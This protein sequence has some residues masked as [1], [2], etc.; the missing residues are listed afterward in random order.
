MFLWNTSSLPIL[1]LGSEF[2]DPVEAATFPQKKLRYWN[3]DIQLKVDPQLFAAFTPLPNNLPQPLALR[4][5]GHQF[6]HYNPHLGDGRGFLFAQ[7]QQNNQWYDLGT[8]GSGPTPYSR[9][10]DGRLTLKGAFRESLATELLQ[11]LGVKTSKTLCFFETG[12]NLVRNDEPSPTRSAVLT[13]F[14]L[15]H[16]R[17]GTFQR[18]AFLQQKE[19][20]K[21]LISYCMHFYYP[22]EL[23]KIDA[24][25]DNL[26]AARFLYNVIES[27]A[28][29]AAQVMMSGFV[30]GVLNTDNISIAGELFDYGPY[31]FM[32]EYDPNFT[33]AYFDEQGLYCFGR[34]PASFLWALHQLAASLKQAYPDLPA[35]EMLQGFSESFQTAIHEN[36]FRRLNLKPLHT[37]EDN[38]LLA[39]FFDLLEKNNLKFEQT[40]FD[41]HSKKVLNTAS[42]LS[43]YEAKSAAD[44][45]KLLEKYEIADQAKAQSPYFQSEKPTTLLIDEIESLWKPIASHDDWSLY[46]QKLQSIR[47]FRNAYT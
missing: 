42:L 20:I 6:Q 12:E 36:F 5:H 22:S 27:N 44:V 11:T 13:R 26:L 40:F 19:N 15:G 41:F 34:Q 28:K 45:L 47:G 2:Y 21:K 18:L 38:K 3:S 35:E 31:R 37:D 23:A 43:F 46:E 16:I 14:S 39:T 29:L 7:I 30:H 9:G 4:Y 17:I 8:K 10:G 25:D 24:E 32:P 33:A 1:Q